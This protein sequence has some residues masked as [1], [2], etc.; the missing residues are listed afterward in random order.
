MNELPQDPITDDL[1]SAYID[2][3][4]TEAE[5]RTVEYAIANDPDVAWQ[6]ETLRQTV[7][8]L[9]D[10]P[11]VPLTRSFVIPEDQVADVLA[12]RRNRSAGAARTIVT[13]TPWQRLLQFLNGGNLLLRN[14]SAV[15]AALFLVV[16]VGRIAL[17]GPALAPVASA[18]EMISMQ[19]AAPASSAFESAPSSSEAVEA[20]AAAVEAAALEAPAAEESGT[21]ESG[22]E[23]RT[24]AMD[25]AP[26]E[27]AQEEVALKTS[28]TDSA[29]DSTASAR[30]SAP[31]AGTEAAES[32]EEAGDAAVTMSVPAPEGAAAA[33]QEA[34]PMTATHGDPTVPAIS[35]PALLNPFQWL[36]PAQPVP[37]SD[38]AAAASPASEESVAS[39]AAPEEAASAEIAP[40]AVASE[41][42]TP[43][44]T[45]LPTETPTLTPTITHT[46]TALTVI[47]VSTPTAAAVALFNAEDEAVAST[48]Q[49]QIGDRTVSE[50]W[51]AIN[52]GTFWFVV[53]LT[54]LGL[55]LLFFVLWLLSRRRHK[56]PNR[57]DRA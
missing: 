30:Q 9:R 3:D 38:G 1:L 31:S 4:V 14:V 25:S 15:A 8:L 12:L 49:T 27:A 18:P 41:T 46:P 2:G 47:E 48:D 24:M 22:T 28:E 35:M 39:E 34:A 29:E 50:T 44:P 56:L 5:Q 6:V 43:T 26:V 21:E 45:P 53:Q 51:T 16:T 32:S 52:E 23:A 42:P 54:A 11:V 10:L 17:V 37:A 57:T 33:A 19:E 20:P 13:A 36:R 55:A 40:L 7:A